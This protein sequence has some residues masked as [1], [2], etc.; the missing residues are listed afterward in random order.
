[1][2]FSAEMRVRANLSPLHV[3]AAALF[4]RQ[5]WGVESEYGRTALEELRGTGVVEDDEAYVIGAIF[6]AAAFLE[7][8]INEL[9]ND[10]M[11]GYE[12]TPFK[13]LAPHAKTSM[14]QKWAAIE[15]KSSLEKFQAAL[16]AAAA[17]PFNHGASPYQAADSL[18]VL[19]NA[20]IHYDPEFIPADAGTSRKK[21]KGESIG[22]H[23]ESRLKRR[24]SLNPWYKDKGNPF[25]PHKCLGHGC[26]EWAVL[27]SLQLADEF[28]KRMGITPTYNNVR[29]RLG[30][31]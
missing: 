29:P 11:D 13:Q 24:F 17:Q 22:E 4:T 23:L 28:S 16:R 20:L 15:R 5:S 2:S 12:S 9:F 19:R 14:A 26:A 8:V 1:M 6:A 7:A 25:Y 27:S 30:T 10:V 3:Q 31:K 21:K 18:I